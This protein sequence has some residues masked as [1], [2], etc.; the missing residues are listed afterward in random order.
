MAFNLKNLAKKARTVAGEQNEKIDS[1][2]DKAVKA[3]DDKTGGKHGDKLRGGADK[4]KG[5]V[6]KVADRKPDARDADT[7]ADGTSKPS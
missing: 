1:T 5:A 6:D 7:D 3:V 4:L 2:I